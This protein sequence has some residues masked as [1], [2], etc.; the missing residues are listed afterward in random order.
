MSSSQVSDSVILMLSRQIFPWEGRNLGI[1][2]QLFQLVLVPYLAALRTCSWLCTSD[3]SCWIDPT[4]KRGTR[5]WTWVCHVQDKHTT[6]STVALAPGCSNFPPF[7][8]FGNPCVA[9]LGDY[10]ELSALGYLL[11]SVGP[12]RYQWCFSRLQSTQSAHLRPVLFQN[13]VSWKL[14]VH[15]RK[16]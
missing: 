12:C 2:I 9:V 3:H 5:S 16:K 14:Y 7:I 11:V 10:S 8:C 6:H 1:W 4:A 13:C 15:S